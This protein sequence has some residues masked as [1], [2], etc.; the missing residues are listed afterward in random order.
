LKEGILEN[1]IKYQK[2][3]LKNILENFDK[4]LTEIENMKNHGFDRIFDAGN[5]K[6]ILERGK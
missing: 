4:E 1:R 2:H 3:K 5:K 6:F